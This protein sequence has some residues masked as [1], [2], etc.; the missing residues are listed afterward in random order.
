MPSV[1]GAAVALDLVQLRR[2]AST[3]SSAELLERHSGGVTCMHGLAAG[4][5]FFKAGELSTL[6]PWPNAS[7]TVYAQ[8]VRDIVGQATSVRGMPCDTT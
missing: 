6:V 8:D 5:H 3:H 7:R 4:F 2:A 1:L